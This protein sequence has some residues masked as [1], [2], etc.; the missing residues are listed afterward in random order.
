MFLASSSFF[1]IFGITRVLIYRFQMR[2]DPLQLWI[3]GV[4]VHHYVWGIALLLLVG[5]LWLIQVGTGTTKGSERLG[6]VTAVLYGA[7][8]AMTL[9]EFAML[10]HMEDVYWERVSIDAVMLFGGLVSAGLWGKPFLRALVRQGARL[11]IWKE[12]EPAHAPVASATAGAIEELLA[13]P[14]LGPEKS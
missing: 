10:V 11:L 1:V 5:Y 6:R 4:H 8:A 3:G 9:D 7:G 2:G 13:P 12:R 14:E